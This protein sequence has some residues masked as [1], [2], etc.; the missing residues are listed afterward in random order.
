M[1]IEN[2]TELVVGERYTYIWCCD[3]N[4]VIYK[5]VFLHE[6]CDHYVFKRLDVG[7]N[8]KIYVSKAPLVFITQRILSK[9]KILECFAGKT[10]W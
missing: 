9:N 2:L 6:T 8:Q 1:I 4:S 10:S 7:L 3:G 5:A